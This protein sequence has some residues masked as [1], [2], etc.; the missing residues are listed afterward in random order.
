MEYGTDVG[1]A[2][3]ETGRAW[4]QFSVTGKKKKGNMKRTSAAKSTTA[5]EQKEGSRRGVGKVSVLLACSK[6]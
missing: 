3:S 2:D 6:P 4:V 1:S 5:T